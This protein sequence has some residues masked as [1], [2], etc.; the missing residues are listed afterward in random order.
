MSTD[1][2]L[3]QR[4]NGCTNRKGVINNMFD[5]TR[6]ITRGVAHEIDPIVQA[7]L[8]DMVDRIPIQK[9][10]LQIF[11][12]S[13]TLENGVAMQKIIHMQEQPAYSTT[14]VIETY[15]PTNY[16]IYVIDDETHSTMLLSTEY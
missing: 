11:Q 14:V 13:F 3:S 4:Y 10:Y 1:N 12:L 7:K 16:K 15:N 6:Y 9:D 8:W 5:N 2:T